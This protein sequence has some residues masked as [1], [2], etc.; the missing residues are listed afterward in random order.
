[1]DIGV[2]ITLGLENGVPGSPLVGPTSLWH[3]LLGHAPEVPPRGPFSTYTALLTHPWGPT[4]LT[5]PP[6]VRP[7]SQWPSRPSRE[8]N[9]A[10]R[11][12]GKQAALCGPAWRARPGAG[13]PNH[14][15]VPR[16]CSCPAPGWPPLSGLVRRPD[17][18]PGNA[19]PTLPTT[20]P[21]A[22]GSRCCARTVEGGS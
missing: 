14:C 10:R 8:R 19:R 6:P 16:C 20:P 18:G 5:H 1:M 21:Q 2:A 7:P 12:A 13:G 11:E 9:G 3:N 22:P 17:A 15:P 4:H